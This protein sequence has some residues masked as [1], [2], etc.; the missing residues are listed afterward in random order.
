[1]KYKP[2]M[3]QHHDFN[4]GAA[5]EMKRKKVESIVLDTAGSTTQNIVVQK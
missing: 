4:C 1:M 2:H 3:V 5:L